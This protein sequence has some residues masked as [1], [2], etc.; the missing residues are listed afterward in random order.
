MTHRGLQYHAQRMLVP[1]KELCESV[2]LAFKYKTV[3][4]LICL[5]KKSARTQVDHCPCSQ[6]VRN[7]LGAKGKKTLKQGV[8]KVLEEAGSFRDQTVKIRIGIQL[9]N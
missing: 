8:L 4:F 9:G 3:Q 2:S 7:V 5:F 1:E 6:P